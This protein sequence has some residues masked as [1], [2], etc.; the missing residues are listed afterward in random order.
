MIKLM[1]NDGIRLVCGWLPPTVPATP[2]LI[3]WGTSVSTGLPLLNAY[4]SQFGTAGAT[5]AAPGSRVLAIAAAV[6]G[7]VVTLKA[8]L[9]VG[10][11][12]LSIVTVGVPPVWPRA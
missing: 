5:G 1:H 8:W 4:N 9:C 10:I 3:G 6:A 7:V 11:V 2:G 12:D